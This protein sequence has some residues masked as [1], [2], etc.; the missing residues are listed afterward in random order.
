MSNQ[1][2]YHF[3]VDANKYETD[4][5]TLTGGEIKA[6]V[7]GLNPT[8]QL[9]VE[10]QGNQPDKLVSDGEAIPLD[11][12]GQGVRKFYSVPPATFGL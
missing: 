7:P 2:K 1:P 9:F 11:P 12:A 3:F 6:L 4:K 10:Q 5:S 8:Y